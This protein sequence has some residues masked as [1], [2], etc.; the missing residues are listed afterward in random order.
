MRSAKNRETE[1]I[2]TLEDLKGAWDMM[3]TAVGLARRNHCVVGGGAF[4]FAVCVAILEGD[5]G[6]CAGGAA[7]EL[8][9]GEEVLAGG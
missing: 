1:H 7:F 5:D 6:M 4:H 3:N 8:H 2:T 9:R